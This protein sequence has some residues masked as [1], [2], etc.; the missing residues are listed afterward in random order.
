MSF[1][2]LSVILSH[3]H[4]LLLMSYNNLNYQYVP[5]GSNQSSQYNSAN[6]SNIPTNPPNLP[7]N[8]SHPNLPP[9]QNHPTPPSH[10]TPQN[11]LP[12]SYP[13]PVMGPYHP[14]PI[15]SQANANDSNPEVSITVQSSPGGVPR[16]GPWSP[17]EDHQLMDLISI[18]GPSNWVRIS[19]SLCTRTPKQCRERYHQNLKPSLNRTP[20]T[21]EEGLLIEKLVA[22]HGKKW[23][24]IARH[25]N[26]RSDN[27][28][29]NWW[30][31][32]ANRRRRASTSVKLVN[33]NPNSICNSDDETGALVGKPEPNPPIA[34]INLP[35]VGS[36]PIPLIR[37]IKPSQYP[38]VQHL[39]QIS[40]NTSIFAA[41][42]STKYSKNPQSPSLASRLSS[43][44]NM[45]NIP[46]IQSPN[47]NPTFVSSKRRLVDE[48][49]TRRHSTA[50]TPYGEM[51]SK[52]HK[53]PISQDQQMNSGDHKS[54][55]NH[56]LALES[57]SSIRSMT[58]SNESR[59]SSIQ[60]LFPN[61]LRDKR[62]DSR[63]LS[64]ISLSSSH[65]TKHLE[66][67]KDQRELDKEE[68]KNSADKK[69]QERN[70]AEKKDHESEEKAKIS[71]SSLI[72]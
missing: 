55:V 18:F 67:T 51:N 2:L 36:P 31:G 59:T 42:P 35:P 45:G 26:G 6:Y 66:E 15:V 7:P 34:G 3:N 8:Q 58:S 30:N 28:I 9:T 25:L 33:S 23:A 39:P 22:K 16:R 11:H 56:D 47:T 1:H 53:S 71:V 21:Q 32:G 62:N 46:H 63:N 64:L 68:R 38:Q 19:N 4:N 57:R 13:Q 12:V 41:S 48:E 60:D 70:S 40:F 49:Q 10:P 65:S 27:A 43:L 69:Y 61:P 37:P 44:D 24:E 52:D 72:D 54:P 50:N 5:P 17:E 14:Y 29:K 20:I